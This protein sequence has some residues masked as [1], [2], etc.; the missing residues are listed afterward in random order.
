[1]YGKYISNNTDI[2]AQ[3]MTRYYLTEIQIITGLT[4]VLL[5]FSAEAFSGTDNAPKDNSWFREKYM[6]QL[7][8]EYYIHTF[9]RINLDRENELD[10]CPEFHKPAIHFAMTGR[11]LWGRV[12]LY[13]QRHY[14]RERE[15]R[16]ERMRNHYTPPDH[17]KLELML[18][19]VEDLG[20]VIWDIIRYGFNLFMIQLSIL[21]TSLSTV[22]LLILMFGQY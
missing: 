19:T 20:W 6:K 5:L 15:R 16:H 3:F 10:N 9:S 7:N 21:L 12:Q 18:V 17:Y 2:I 8:N 13:Q 11:Q 1:M 4:M 14:E 22:I